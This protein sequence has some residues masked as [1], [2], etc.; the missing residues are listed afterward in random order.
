MKG[1][2]YMN[3]KQAY[4]IIQIAECGI[5][6]CENFMEQVFLFYSNHSADVF[7]Y[8]DN[9]T[10]LMMRERFHCTALKNAY[11]SRYGNDVE[12]DGLAE[13]IEML[14]A[15]G[16]STV[17]VKQAIGVLL[18]AMKLEFKVVENPNM[19]ISFENS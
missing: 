9:E 15:A 10:Q 7:L 12:N 5:G 17:L 11:R 8:Q 18:N 3:M 19:V 2:L 16:D 13:A 14:S 4:A 6:I 1:D